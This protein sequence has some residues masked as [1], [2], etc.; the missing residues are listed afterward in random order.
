MINFLLSKMTISIM[1]S[2]DSNL[3]AFAT[4]TNTLLKFKGFLHTFIPLANITSCLEEEGEGAQR[5]HTH[6]RALEI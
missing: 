3:K 1:L 4:R 5:Y 6:Q 2:S